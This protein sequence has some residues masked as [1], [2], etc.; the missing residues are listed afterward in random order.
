MEFIG[1]KSFNELIQASLEGQQILKRE[2]LL[3]D[4]IGFP[5]LNRYTKNKMFLREGLRDNIR[6]FNWLHAKGIIFDADELLRSKP[7]IFT[8]ESEFYHQAYHAHFDILQKMERKKR[9]TDKQRTEFLA[10]TSQTF[11]IDSILTSI[12]LRNNFELDAYPVYYESF[13]LPELNT[14]NRNVVQIVLKSLPIPDEQTSWEQINEFRGDTDS[15]SKFLA[16]R[17]WMAEVARAELTPIEI[18]QKLE[19]LIDQYLQHIR[20]H[21]MKANTSIVETIVV[22][23]AELLEDTIK[24]KW[25]DMAKKLFSLKQRKI[26]LFEG[27]LTNP[28]R[29]VAYIIKAK[30]TFY[31]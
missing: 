23:T 28:G 5:A 15:K 10:L 30:K 2:A 12:N 19:Y 11:R 1:V 27:E 17:N 6:D 31:R 25:G 21:K 13:I 14:S 24:F 18:E 9:K 4:R 7:L 3:F 22:T 26:A 29:E 20:L 16:L 8:E